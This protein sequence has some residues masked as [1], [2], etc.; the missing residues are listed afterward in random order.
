MRART[1]YPASCPRRTPTWY[2][3]R[4]TTLG[5]RS[6]QF[7]HERRARAG[8]GANVEAAAHPVHELP[9][10]VEPEPRAAGSRELRPASVELVEDPR[11]LGGRQPRARVL[12]R[13]A[14]DPVHGPDANGDRAAL[15]VLD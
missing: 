1:D 9:R 8:L 7:E 14:D 2:Q 5:L 11:L 13:Q 10:D 3:G 6:R 4:R 15:A 12:H